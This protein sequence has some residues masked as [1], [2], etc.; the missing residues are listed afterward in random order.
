M[1]WYE[2]SLE[3]LRNKIGIETDNRGYANCPF[4][5]AKKKLKFTDSKNEW[6]CNKC[7]AKGGVM[8]FFARYQLGIE[9]F[10]DNTSERSIISKKLQE[11]MG[12]SDATPPP[13]TR[14]HAKPK[15]PQRPVAKD[16]QLHAVY[17][18]MASL[19]VFQL[20][21][22][23]KKELN[24]RGLTDTQ[25]ERNG[26][27][28]YPYKTKIPDQIVSLYYSTDP[29]L[30]DGISQNEATH[31]QLGLYVAHLLEERGFALDGIPGFYKFGSHWCLTY[32]PGIMIPTRNINGQIVL[33]QIRKKKGSPKYL[34]LSCG[35]K[36]GAVDEAVSRCHFPLANAAPS[37]EIQV[38]FTEGPLK[39]DVAAAMYCDPCCFI[40]ILGVSNTSDLLA[41]CKA[42][43][44]AG[45]EE[46]FNALD[47]D[48]LTNPHVRE[49]SASLEDM[50]RK[51]GMRVIPMYWG[52]QYA[53]Q[54]LML[55]T[56]IANIRGVP[57]PALPPHFSVFDNLR[58]VAQALKAVGID[59]G[60]QT[61][62][63]QYWENETKGIDDYLFSQK[64]RKG[65][66]QKPKTGF[67]QTYHKALLRI[68]DS[69]SS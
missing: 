53:S 20:L 57:V 32:S 40:A 37:R 69:S 6:R 50:L 45:V 11:F 36:P 33:W 35:S 54:Q 43:K 25:I 29:S 3:E 18:A 47:M 10:P 55:Y 19:A 2:V 67:M 21:P 9:N 16:A 44:K 42:L 52:D 48:K 62:D 12:Y 65:H 30:R 24:R 31:I 68:N 51:R 39:A 46:M 61:P 60:C 64:Q 7:D 66:S 27:R 38:I 49:R 58:N 59:P 13:A 8:K 15:G 17:S 5:G 28:S 4:C 22:E 41:N 26:Y 1:A 14:T 56:S 63:S 23:H 34:T